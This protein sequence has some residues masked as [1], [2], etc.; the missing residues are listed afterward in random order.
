[1]AAALV[2]AE[3]GASLLLGSPLPP[4]AWAFLALYWI[5]ALAVAGAA[6][7]LVLSHSA[8]MAALVWLLALVYCVGLA[9][10]DLLAGP[11]RWTPAHAAAC[12]VSVTVFASAA[13]ICERSLARR[14][15][16]AVQ[17]GLLRLLLVPAAVA[18]AQIGARGLRG[19][20]A[21]AALVLPMAVAA[22][23][24]LAGIALAAAA[25]RLSARGALGAAAAVIAAVALPAAWQAGRPPSGALRDGPQPAPPATGPTPPNVVLIVMDAVRAGSVSSYGYE[26]RT[27]PHLDAF[28]AGALRFAAA[29]TVSSWSVPTHASLFTG[30]FA[31]E[32][33]AG[34][35]QRDARTGLL[36][37]AALDARFVTLAEDLAGRGYATAGISA[38]PL[39]A[40]AMGLAQGFRFFD[41]RPSPRA[42]APGYRS[43]LQRLQ[44]VLPAALLAEPLRVAFPRAMR[45]GAEITDAA[46]D[47]LGRRPRGQ[48]Y[49]L[50]VNYMDAHT[51]FVPR[52]GFSGRWP[53]RSPHL[54]PYGL[55]DTVAV[56]AGR[57]RLTAEES[58]H[59]RALY[60]D[61]LSYLDHHLGRLL[62]ALDAQPDAEDAWIIV[63]AD[64]GEQ[65]G[66][67]G[68]IGHDC[69]LLPQVLHVP[70]LVRYPRGFPEA[71]RHGR[72]EERPVQLTDLQPAILGKGALPPP[73]GASGRSRV[74]AASVDCFCWRDHPQFHGAAAR[75][76]VQG[77]LQYL[78]EQDRAPALFDFTDPARELPEALRDEAPRMAA[79]LE[80]WKA[81]LAPALPSAGADESGREEALAALGYIR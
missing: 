51:P 12:A 58:A 39:V 15:L 61:A 81:G 24:I 34:A 21:S 29:T 1:V 11:A 77:G 80:R 67:H 25:A 52:S 66:E 6:G 14:R 9:I 35:P 37:P 19:V 16:G 27:T 74:V 41:A 23:V 46:V 7:S 72:T 44:G 38:N 69:V 28:A 32:H 18:A 53:G 54:P 4:R 64:H 36:R 60:D 70:L 65:L 8:V 13:L 30:L 40:P 78:D 71:A 3:A 47:W 43:L 57:R 2:V 45:S 59:L 5:P 55:G 56:M 76:V 68:R 48:P 75:A 49:L 17:A 62:A 10:Q 50:F 31:P 20:A 26:R 22:A 33:G 73:V 79:E 42:L 63:T